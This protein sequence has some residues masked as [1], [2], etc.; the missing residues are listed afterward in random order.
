M[1]PKRATPESI[2]ERGTG[3]TKSARLSNR[4]MGKRKVIEVLVLA[5]IGL[6]LNIYIFYLG[7]WMLR[8]PIWGGFWFCTICIWVLVIVGIVQVLRRSNDKTDKRNPSGQ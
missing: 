1:I 7:K 6:I 3:S 8:A 2:E 5:L 4:A